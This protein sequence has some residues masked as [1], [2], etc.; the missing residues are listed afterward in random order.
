MPGEN[1]PLRTGVHVPV[2]PEAGSRHNF[3]RAESGNLVFSYKYPHFLIDILFFCLIAKA[4]SS[5]M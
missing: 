1:S 3:A 2:H 5:T 4:G